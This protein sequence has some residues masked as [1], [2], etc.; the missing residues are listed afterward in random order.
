MVAF[1]KETFP[2]PAELTT[3]NVVILTHG[4]FY[5]QIDGIGMVSRP[6]SPLS[7]MKYDTKVFERY[8]NKALNN[9][10]Q[11]IKVKLMEINT[12]Q[13]NLKVTQQSKMLL[14]SVEKNC[15]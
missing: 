1:D 4:E 15:R 12:L 14:L 8:M 13:S 7:N 9:E 6:A 5:Y 10:E 3:T 2:I 11:F